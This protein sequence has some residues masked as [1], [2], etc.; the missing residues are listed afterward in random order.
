MVGRRKNSVSDV[1]TSAPSQYAA[2][3]NMYAICMIQRIVE[4][5]F[6]LL[7]T[8]HFLL[9]N[10]KFARN[11]SNFIASHYMA[12]HFMNLDTDIRWLGTEP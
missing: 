1:R 4:L 6:E 3:N 11:V 5:C 10:N 12:L 2:K 7:M 9:G 8:L